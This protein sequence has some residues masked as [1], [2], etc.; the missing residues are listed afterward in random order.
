MSNISAE[1]TSANQGD[2]FFAK[3]FDPATGKTIAHPVFVV[4]K[5]NDSNDSHDVIICNCT[6][7]P[8]RTDYDVL[9]Q[10]KYPTLVRTN[11][12]YTIQRGQ[13]HFEINHNLDQTVI[14]TLLE[15][16]V[17]AIRQ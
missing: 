16:V 8:K 7:Q 10:L 13:L 11:K 14:S 1:Q 15:S 9:V 12:L 4:G 3:F 2:F 17:K 6:S 5:N